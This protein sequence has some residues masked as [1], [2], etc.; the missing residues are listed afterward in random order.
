MAPVKMNYRTS[1][2]L[3]EVLCK[4]FRVGLRSAW[5]L[6]C[7]AVFFSPLF[8]QAEL[9]DISRIFHQ[10]PSLQELEVCQGGGCAVDSK[11]ALTELEWNAV[12]RLFNKPAQN[13]QEERHKIAQAIGVLED[14]VGKKVGTTNDLA[15]T[16]FD[17][18]LAG[19]QDCNDEAIN[20]TTYMRLL[21]SNGFMQFH[22]IEDMRTRNFFF[23][24]WPHTTAVI[25]EI[26]T[27]ERFAVDSWF[28]DNGHVAT[29][30]PFSEWKANFQ[31]ADSP[32]GKQRTI[33]SSNLQSGNP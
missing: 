22:E 7:S 29:I 20:S 26:K 10:T 32:I 12:A 25:R 2:L 3:C 23:T 16:F 21:K 5:I 31:P 8:A 19:Q 33:K 18:K 9:K 24:G 4:D 17:G 14:I 11:A 30:V 13:V 1:P 28:Y 15:G 27:G 6:A